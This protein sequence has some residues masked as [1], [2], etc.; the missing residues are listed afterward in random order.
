MQP[1]TRDFF[2]QLYKKKRRPKS[3]II[4]GLGNAPFPRTSRPE[5]LALAVTLFRLM[6]AGWPS[7]GFGCVEYIQDGGRLIFTALST[8]GSF[9]Q[10]TK[11]L[12]LP[13]YS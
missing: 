8:Q 6:V 10:G 4:R 11:L 5:V 12:G 2:T 13:V 1:A 7:S 9:S 3:R